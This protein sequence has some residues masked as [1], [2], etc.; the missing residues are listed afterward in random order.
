MKVVLK[1]SEKIILSQE[2]L[3]LKSLLVFYSVPKRLNILYS[4]VT[5]KSNLSLRLFDWFPTNYAKNNKVFINDKN[6][7]LKYKDNLKGYNKKHFDPFCRKRRIFLKFDLKTITTVK[8]IKFDYEFL[9]EGCH[10]EYENREDGIVTTV[11]QMNFFK[12]CIESDI[13]QYMFENA[14]TI[15]KDMNLN[16][17]KRKASKENKKSRKSNVGITKTYMK[18]VVRF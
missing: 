6:I 9:D 10:K 2:E 14:K 5:Q 13:V 12:W 16:G 17:A 3:L 11:G 7:Y 4:I 1:E 15:E 18:V 8:K